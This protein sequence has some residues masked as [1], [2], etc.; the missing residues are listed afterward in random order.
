MQ[1]QQGSDGLLFRRTLSGQIR[2]EN[3]NL[4]FQNTVFGF[5]DSKSNRFADTEARVHCGLVKGDLNQTLKMFWELENVEVERTK[6]E[7]TIFCEDH[8][9]KTHSRD[10]K[11]QYMLSRD[12][13]KNFPLA[14]PV[15][16]ENFFMDDVLCGAASL[17]EA[18]ALKNQLSGILKK[19]GMKLHK[20]GSSQPE[21]ASN[22]I[23]D[24]E[25]ENP[26]ETKTLGVSWK[27]QEDCF[28]FKIAVELKDSYTKRRVLSTIAR[29]FDPLGLLGP[30]VA[31]AKIFMQ[32]LWS[33]K[34]DWIDELP[35]ERAKE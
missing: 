32:S 4:I 10:D 28:I 17:M 18:K 33:L 6:N 26:I 12:E 34:I 8:F 27:S 13:E 23:G 20:W 16:I 7:E 25:F 3:S 9:L 5:V 22:I 35:S 30:V 2:S 24:Y 11:G 29:L 14:A 1:L 21:L 15:L 19:G 31:R